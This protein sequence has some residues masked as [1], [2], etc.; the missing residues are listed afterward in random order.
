V[1][2]RASVPLRSVPKV[3]R[4]ADLMA[5]VHESGLAV[6]REALPLAEVHE[7]PPSAAGGQQGRDVVAAA[8]VR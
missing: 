6:A 3:R 1:A 8:L 7:V 4:E 2:E 5:A